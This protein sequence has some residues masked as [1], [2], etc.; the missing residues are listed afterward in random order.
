MAL[1]ISKERG[2]QTFALNVFEEAELTE[3]EG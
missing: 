1:K 3:D 2:V